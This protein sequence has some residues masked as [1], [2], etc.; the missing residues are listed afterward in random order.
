MAPIKLDEGMQFV[1]FE[2]HGR[3]FE[4]DPFVALEKLAAVDRQ[5]DHLM[6]EQADGGKQIPAEVAGVW[7]DAIAAHICEE[8]N[9][10]RCSRFAANQFYEYILRVVG[11]LKKKVSWTLASDIGSD[12]TPADGPSGGS[13]PSLQI[14][15]DSTPSDGLPST[16]GEVGPTSTFT[17]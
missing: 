13:E 4:V 15:P 10:P 12:S 11:E 3:V 9:A 6:D 16:I 14:F 17:P 1:Q 5:F 8:Y 7:R 2:L